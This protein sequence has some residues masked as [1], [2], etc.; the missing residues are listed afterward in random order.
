MA[1]LLRKLKSAST[2]SKSAKINRFILIKAV[3]VGLSRKK[4]A[5]VK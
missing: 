1:S 4:A 3:A 2:E 5:Q